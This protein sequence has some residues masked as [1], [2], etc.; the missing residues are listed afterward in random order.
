[1]ARTGKIAQLPFTVREQL[2]EMLLDGASGAQILGWVNAQPETKAVA[3]KKGWTV[4]EITDGNL[5]EWRA[6]GHADWV[7]ER[8]KILRME[9]WVELSQRLAATA[10]GS[11]AGAASDVAAGKIMELLMDEAAL[12]DSPE[13]EEGNN[14]CSVLSMSKAL[15]S[16]RSAETAAR[17]A[18]TDLEKVTIAQAKLAQDQQRLEMQMEKFRRE[19][20]GNFLDWT[21]DERVKAIAAGKASR[22]EKV[23]ALSQLA[24]LYF[25]E[26]PEDAG[27]P[28]GAR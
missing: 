9:S 22:E 5:S 20:A 14:A 17:K 19:M 11:L 27:L 15:A 25:G 18:E 10:G 6:G 4:R 28:A 8:S 23:H 7:R 1:M 16:L 24:D 3:E 2:N 26:A 13:G 12:P 21:E